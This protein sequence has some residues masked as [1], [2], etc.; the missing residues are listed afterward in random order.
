MTIQSVSLMGIIIVYSLVFFIGSTAGWLLELFFRRFVSQKRWVNPGFCTGPYLPIYGIG[1]CALFTITLLEQTRIVSPTPLNK[2]WLFL[3]M[4]AVMT[5]IEYIGGMVLLKSYK[6]RLWDYTDM[7]GNVNGVICPQ[8]SAGW[9]LLSALYYFLIHPRI[10]NALYWMSENLA[11]S[12]FVGVF[13]GVFAMDFGRSAQIAARLKQFAV[14]NGV[15]VRFEAVKDLIRQK[16][17]EAKQRMSFFRPFRSDIPLPDLLMEL[18]ESFEK[19]V[20]DRLKQPG[21]DDQ[22]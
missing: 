20:P 3:S 18:R 10:L 5:L 13:M 6:I 15:I 21:D 1:L 22:I 8:Y 4:A 12:F 16:R 19:S 11:F 2:A 7:P 9:A 17:E 14:E